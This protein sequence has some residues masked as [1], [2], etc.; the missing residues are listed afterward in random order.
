MIK[1]VDAFLFDCVVCKMTLLNKNWELIKSLLRKVDDEIL[2]T[3]RSSNMCCTTIGKL[4]KRQL[5]K[6]KIARQVQLG[7][8][9]HIM[10]GN[11]KIGRV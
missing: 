7:W 5:K 3:S 2:F 11:H 10:C 9:S 6:A 1:L 4:S 8:K